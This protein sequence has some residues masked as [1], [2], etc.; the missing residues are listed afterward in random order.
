M[1]DGLTHR[2]QLTLEPATDFTTEERMAFS[3]TCRKPYKTVFLEQ[4]AEDA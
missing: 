2:I 3:R 1:S 4:F